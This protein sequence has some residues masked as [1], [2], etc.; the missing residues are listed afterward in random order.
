MHPFDST[1]RRG[2]LARLAGAAA[3][4]AGPSIP[5]GALAAQATDHDRWITGLKGR[6]RC[7]FDF[8]LHAGGLPL[9]HMYNY[10]NTYKAAYSEWD[11]LRRPTEVLFPP[12]FRTITR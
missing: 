11:Y 9:I 8:P 6:H 5:F 7:L 12:S 2:F 3:L 4:A 1:P 10:V